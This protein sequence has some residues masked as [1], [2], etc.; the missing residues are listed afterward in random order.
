MNRHKLAIAFTICFI[1][2]MFSGVSSMLMSVYLPVA[3]R[4]LLGEMNDESMNSVSAYINSF[5]LFGSMFGGF[6][7]GYICDRIGRSKAVTF[8]TAFYALFTLL[9]AFSGSWMLVSIYRFLTGFGVGGVMLTT[10]I[11][12]CEL[13]PEN[14]R[15]VAVGIVS[16]A[17]PVGFIAAGALNNVLANW[18]SAFLVGAIPLAT[19]VVSAFIL[20]ESEGWKAGKTNNSAVEVSSS[21]IFSP[22]YRRNLLVGSLIFGT[23]LI[24]LWA[25]FS[26]A[27]TW[28]QSVTP[29]ES[30][31]QQLRGTTMM[32]LAFSG[33]LGSVAS[34]WIAN[35]LGQRNTLIMCF[36]MCFIMVFVVFKL[37]T[38]I[39]SATFAEMFVMAFFFG[40]SQGV[41]AVYI[42]QLFPTVI[43]AFATGFCY[44]IGRLFTAS[45]VFFIGALAD[46]LGGYGN[47]I[48]IFSFIF[49]IGLVITGFA[50]L[51]R[52]EY[53]VVKQQ[54]NL[55]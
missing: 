53:P 22:N 7:W 5:F 55:N 33:L 25:V 9:T 19:A 15:A 38:S 50:G 30:D 1:S 12:V 23:M 45:V 29:N 52:I 41:L 48:F 17:M 8:S 32:I 10:N 54:S 42:P 2:I 37:N 16:A 18:H 39:T 35:A 31:A 49:L 44:N 24:G 21:G 36:A 14:K 51:Q 34:G 6:S 26:W 40:I 43:R 46:F 20:S 28:V 4:D 27:P 11:L 47:A 3:V 13:W